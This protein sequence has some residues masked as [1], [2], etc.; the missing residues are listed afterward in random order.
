[1]GA[2]VV[3]GLAEQIKG[4]PVS[5]VVPIRDHQNFGRARDHVDAHLA[6]HPPF[7]GS[8][9]GIAGAGDLV[10]GG[11]RVGAIGQCGHRL[12]PTDAVNLVNARQPRSQQHQRVQHP[13]RRGHDHRKPFYPRDLG[14]D[15]VHQDRGRIACQTT[16]HIKPCG[17]YRAPPPAE[18]GT[19]VVLPLCILGQLPF[20]IGTDTRRGEFKR[21]AIRVRDFGNRGVDF[22]SGDAQGVGGQRDAVE[23][24]GQLDHGGIAFG[25]HLRDDLGHCVVHVGAVFT[26]GRKQRGERLFEIGLI[27]V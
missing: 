17:G 26:F 11:D 21:C 24:L 6:K 25:P 16:G 27:E 22:S 10:D 14:R 2:F 1:M 19:G 15:R 7:R 20:V 3:F 9:I 13:V 23:L 8:D 4:D 5:I 18:R 12:R